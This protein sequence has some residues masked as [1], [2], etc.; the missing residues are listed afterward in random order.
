MRK[1][2]LVIIFLLSVVS[3]PAKELFSIKD[4][5]PADK[6]SLRITVSA[7]T[8]GHSSVWDFSQ[9]QKVDVDFHVLSV[10]KDSIRLAIKPI[11]WFTCFQSEEQL[12]NRQTDL[13]YF[14]TDYFGYYDDK[15]MFYLFDNNSVIASL[16]TNDKKVNISYAD[17]PEEKHTNRYRNRWY[18]QALNIPQ[19]LRMVSFV[20]PISDLFIDF[21]IITKSAL[22]SFFKEWDEKN[23]KGA[24]MPWLIDLRSEFVSVSDKATFAQLT[25][26]S[27]AIQP[28]THIMFTAS[29]D[30][31]EDRIFIEMD[32]ERMKPV[33]SVNYTYV[34]SFFLSS[35]KRMNIRDIIL[36]ITPEDS[37]KV[38]YNSISRNYEFEGKGYANSAYINEI[39]KLYNSNQPDIYHEMD[40]DI[41]F[42]EGEELHVS[43]LSKYQSNMNDYWRKSA[44]LSFDYWYASEKL[45]LYNEN[46]TRSWGEPVATED[47]SLWYNKHFTDLFPFADY[48]YQPYTYGAL[49]E[50]F[51]TYKAQEANNSIMTGIRYLQGHIPKYYFADAVFWGYPRFYL[52]SETLKYIM[53]NFHLSE[54]E[55]EYQDFI[56]KCNVTELRK[57]VIDLHEKL[58]KVD[59]GANIKDLDLK[60]ENKI[61]LK[62]KSDG[63]VILLVRNSLDNN[64]EDLYFEQRLKNIYTEIEKAELKDKVNVCIITSESHKSHFDS[65]PEIQ[66]QIIFVPD[67]NV[68]EFEDKLVSDD[69][70]YM[71]IRNNGIIINREQ[72]SNRIDSPYFLIRNIQEDIIKQNDQNSASGGVLIVI[73]T[74]LL[75]ILITFLLVR[76]IIRRREKRRRQMLE[77]ELKAIRAQMNPHFTFN[78]LGSIQN[79]IS[80]KKEK[81][82]NDYLVNFARLLRMVLSTSEK[83]LV[84]LSEEISL[85]ELYLQLE[86]LR[87]SFEYVIDID[88]SLDVENEEI[89]GML[90]QPIVENAVKHGIAPKGGGK[91]S[92]RFNLTNH[93]LYVAVTDTGSGYFEENS[94]ANKGFGLR[95]VRERLGLLNKEYHLNI[96]LK[97]ENIEEGGIVKGC[98]VTLSI[99][100]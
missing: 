38:K 71:V 93:N 25:S 28:N 31:P 83:K 59:P 24:T 43:L 49:V 12:K 65:K 22:E 34:F 84:T 77:L 32:G 100:V 10:D 26:A 78:A 63:Y 92:I 45:K 99:P 47:M 21:D 11:R 62:N 27:F 40:K 80:Q 54:S 50:S 48:L 7:G 64:K 89:P 81:E 74:S 3:I 73:I 16:N 53:L 20:S 55:R 97:I 14:N 36:D 79:L 60:I 15:P 85:L 66:K 94:G 90:I 86:Q 95:S 6:F 70:D 8:V 33:K 58:A 23:R 39:A 4:L 69:R 30:I 17:S 91:I 1:I 98:K 75:S 35:P 2:L 52:T 41:F 42:R 56:Q 9:T 57:S 19:G 13:A 68:R 18:M 29:K 67:A 46:V 82:A 5:K 96:N 88:E 76:F 61:P 37:L 44:K 51:Y 87:V 72:N